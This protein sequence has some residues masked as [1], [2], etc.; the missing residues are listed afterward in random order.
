MKK[1]AL[2]YSGCLRTLQEMLPRHCEYFLEH[3]DSLDLYFSL[4]DHVGYVNHLNDEDFISAQRLTPPHS[5][6][7]PELI[8]SWVTQSNCQVVGSHIEKYHPNNCYF[9]LLNGL[10]NDNLAAQYYKIED[11]YKLVTNPFQYRALVRLRTDFWPRQPFSS[12]FLIQ[13]LDQK[14]AIFPHQ[15][16]RGFLKTPSITDLNES[17]WI[18]PP[19]I[20][21]SLCQIYSNVEKI[22][23]IIVRRQQTGPNY[24]ENICYLNVEAENLTNQLQYFDF[25]YKIL[26]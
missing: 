3:A 22:N 26:R 17:C 10:A 25:D 6:I 12:S 13:A 5:L 23:R 21:D 7:T 14:H 11:C 20:M 16:W 19:T 9:P 15:I 1:I 24:G 8:S 2:L 18:A 4:W